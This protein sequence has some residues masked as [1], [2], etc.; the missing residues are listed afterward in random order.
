MAGIIDGNELDASLNIPLYY[1][2]VVIFKRL[3]LNGTLKEGDVLPSELELCER[4]GISRSTVRQAFASLE[5]EGIVERHRGKGTFVSTPKLS[6]RLKNLY[7]FSEEMKMT[8]RRPE[9][10]TLAFELLERPQ[11]DLVGRLKLNSGDKIYKMVRLRIADGE[12]IILETV[13]VPEKFCPGL[14]AEEL[15]E[16]TLYHDILL[17][18][19]GVRAARATETYE[20]TIVDK[21]EA[22]LLKCKPMSGAFFVQRLSY[23]EKDE[24]FELALMLVRGDKCKYEIELGHDDVS[25]MRTFDS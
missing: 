16:K 15:E 7:S 11:R 25:V 4:F 18:E 1:Q 3:I 2:L 21:N 17:G 5:K 24:V 13:F 10:Q 20:C 8:G 6:R 9:S 12:P 19:H 22:E 14:T 23:T